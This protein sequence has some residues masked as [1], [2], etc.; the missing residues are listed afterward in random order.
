MEIISML[1]NTLLQWAGAVAIIIIGVFFVLG[2]WDKTAKEKRKQ[3]DGSEDRL[4]EILQK[5]VNEMEKKVEKQS[6]DLEL[7]THKVEALE[8][9]NEVLIKVLQGRDE[10]TQE[11]Y[12][13]AF[14][15]ID[16]INKSLQII[17]KIERKLQVA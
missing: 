2:I 12:A 5:T 13:K 3:I 16:T 4:I 9:E 7:L 6:A 14:P 8:K 1:P 17:E 15:A 11:F 10:K